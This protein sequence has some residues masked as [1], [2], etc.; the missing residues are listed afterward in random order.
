MMKISYR[1]N[2][3]SHTTDVY[4][5]P[6]I[7]AEVA[8]LLPDGFRTTSVV[9]ISDSNV[10]PLY[11]D[12]VRGSFREFGVETRSFT[13]KA[14]EPSKTLQTASQIYAFLSDAKM[15]R[16]GLVVALGGG[17]VGDLAGLVAG[18]WMRGVPWLYCPTTLEADV[19]ACLGGKTAVNL[20]GGKNL[21]GVFHH[22]MIVAVDPN[23]L[24]T[25][26]RRD[27]RAGLAEAI[28]HALLQSTQEV[29]WLETHAARVLALD[30]EPVTELIE[31]NLRFKGQI[32]S[33]DPDERLDRRIIL[34]F[35]HTVGHAIEA[36]AE[37]ALR[38]GE[39]VSLGMLAA[40]RISHRA[41]L[42]GVGEVERVKNLLR[43]VGLPT[44]LELSLD[45]EK[46]LETL[47]LD[48]K[49][50]GRK[51]RFVLLKGIGAPVIR[52]DIPTAWIAEAYDSLLST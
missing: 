42:L 41:G 49:N 23:C 26:P 32:V 52:D 2:A 31:R 46:V 48:K 7:L 43:V 11:S 14:G 21:V 12:R 10:E 44:K 34:N 51:T 36:C 1:P 47:L 17:V 4:I 24:G 39:C 9:L 22:P 33:E 25:L 6:G 13:F 5:K 30:S 35:G 45:R 38:H 20:S 37:G 8:A 15:P 28:K 27:I 16:D 50:S 40:C 3:P 29:E 18:T 19:D